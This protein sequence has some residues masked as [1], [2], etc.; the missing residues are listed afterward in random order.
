VLRISQQE[1]EE[2]D[3]D[4]FCLDLDGAVGHFTT[5]GFKKLPKSAAESK[6]NLN[7]LAEY[8]L[9]AAP[10]HSG[11][12]VD[13]EL[14][15]AIAEPQKRG[16]RYL[17]SFLSMA[18]KGLYSYDIASYLTSDS[19]YFRVASPS[20]PLQSFELPPEIREILGRTVLAIRFR[21]NSRIAYLS[22]L[23]A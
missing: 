21:E 8:F 22:T 23:E 1:Q 12:T 10:S 13:P 5:A 9:K 11:H 4:W 14:S 20:K 19:S 17:R 6:E 18:D 2:T 7:L 15:A 3:F 16:E